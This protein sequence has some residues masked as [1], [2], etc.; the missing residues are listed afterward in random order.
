MP[1]A[2]LERDPE[3]PETPR[4]AEEVVLRVAEDSEAIV[5]EEAGAEA[6]PATTG[7]EAESAVAEAV[8]AMAGSN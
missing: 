5:G 4:A 3:S 1:G 6:A 2:E 8:D 7:N